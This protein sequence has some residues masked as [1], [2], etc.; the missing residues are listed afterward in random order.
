MKDE[1]N[2]LRMKHVIGRVNKVIYK[3]DYRDEWK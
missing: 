1:M 2:M 3:G